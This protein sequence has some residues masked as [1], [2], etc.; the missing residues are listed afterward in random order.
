MAHGELWGMSHYQREAE[1]YEDASGLERRMSRSTITVNEYQSV[2]EFIVEHHR[3]TVLRVMAY[4]GWP[5][6]RYEEAFKR[7]ATA[8]AKSPIA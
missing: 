5:I 1:D 6:E 3:T 8:I 4:M 7:S 2:A